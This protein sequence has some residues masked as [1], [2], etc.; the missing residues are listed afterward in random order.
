MAED[1]GALAE[2]LWHCM[3]GGDWEGAEALLHEDFVQ[4]WPQS[5]ERIVGRE[6]A[7][8]VNRNFPGGMP[9]ITI[10]RVMSAGD[11]AT[12][13]VDLAYHDGS[14]YQGVSIIECREGRVARETDYFAQDFPAPQWRAQ[15]VER[16]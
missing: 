4:V 2:R 3:S 8:A 15:W 6:N 14:R 10:R 7:L 5:G 12:V 9:E 1:V 13:E 11:L 16:A